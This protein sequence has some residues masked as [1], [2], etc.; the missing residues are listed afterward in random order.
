MLFRS[1]SEA[2]ARYRRSNR[3]GVR[4]HQWL[5]WLLDR[6]L[7]E[8]SRSIELMTDLAIGVHPDGAEAWLYQ[9]VLADGISVGAPPDPFN[10]GGQDWGLPP[11]NPWS[12][13]AAGYEP[14]IETVRA[15]LRHAAALR[16]DHVMGLFR[17]YWIPVGAGPAAGAY[18]RYPDRELL[19]IL[20]LESTRARAYVVGEDLGTVEDRVRSELQARRILSYRLLW[21]EQ[22]PPREYPSQAMAAVT[23][24]D[25]PT[26][27]GVWERTD[28][29]PE[30]RERLKQVAGLEEGASVDEAVLA[31]Y[32]ALAEAP[33][34]LISATLDDLLSVAERPN[35]PGTVEEWPNWRLGLPSPLEE[36]MEDPRPPRIAAVLRRRR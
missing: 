9:D 14:Y 28:S 36:L 10:T 2:V 33:S 24:H 22:S 20:A 4:F 30:I 13:R 8:A 6:Q 26:V 3:Q 15:A 31:A 17:L 1:R 16:I 19:D 7:E 18:V 12:L 23:T 29:D 11:F 35:R 34:R 5:Q 27:A 25:L 21:F 32:R